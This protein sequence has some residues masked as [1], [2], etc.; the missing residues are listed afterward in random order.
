MSRN[1]GPKRRVQQYAKENHLT[2][3]Q[4]Q[5]KLGFTSGDEDYALPI[6]MSVKFG[7]DDRGFTDYTLHDQETIWR[8]FSTRT[9]PCVLIDGMLPMTASALAHQAVSHSTTPVTDIL[10]VAPI[11]DPENNDMLTWMTTD[12]AITFQH[13]AISNEDI[14]Y[15]TAGKAAAAV[16]AFNPRGVGIVVLELE[17]PYARVTPASNAED[18]EDYRGTQ[19]EKHFRPQE[20]T[21]G[22]YWSE[23]TSVVGKAIKHVLSD[24]EQRRGLP[25]VQ[26]TRGV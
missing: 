18:F 21:D 20:L 9:G 15:G 24:D 10:M 25:R 5:R 8:P 17:D 3:Q 2:H 11:L 7:T 6:G 1:S 26:L 22:P 19:W 12:P 16:R 23:N 13:F 14:G 4:A